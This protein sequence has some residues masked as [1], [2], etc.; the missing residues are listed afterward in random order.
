MPSIANNVNL[1]RLAFSAQ[2]QG[3]EAK[4]SKL[5]KYLHVCQPDNSAGKLGLKWLKPGCECLSPASK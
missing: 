2:Y 1:E 5:F 4:F 3:P